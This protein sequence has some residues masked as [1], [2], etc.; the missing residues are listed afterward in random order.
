MIDKK[1]DVVRI[2]KEHISTIKSTTDLNIKRE[3]LRA[4]L[5]SVIVRWHPNN[6]KHSVIITYK[7]DKLSQ[8]VIGK[9]IDLTYSKAGYR[10][11]RNSVFDESLFIR[12]S[13]FDGEDLFG[14]PMVSIQ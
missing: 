11:N 4:I 2:I 1:E 6:Q 12:K 3:L 5:E 13:L 7:I 14:M 9:T 10:L 8:F